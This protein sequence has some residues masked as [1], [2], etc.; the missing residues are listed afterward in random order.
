MSSLDGMLEFVLGN[1]YYLVVGSVALYVIKRYY[2]DFRRL[3]AFKGPWAA[4]FTELW[5]AQA[6]FGTEQHLVLANTCEKYG[7]LSQDF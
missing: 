3:R 5:W 1:K 4:N 7:T 2:D 6:A